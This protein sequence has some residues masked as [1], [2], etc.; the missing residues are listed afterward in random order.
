MNGSEGPVANRRLSYAW[1]T[2]LVAIAALASVVVLLI[3]AHRGESDKASREEQ[4]RIEAENKAKLTIRE[5]EKAHKAE[6]EQRQRAETARDQA[7]AKAEK[8]ARRQRNAKE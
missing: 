7:L 5:L 3:F 1:L 4:A 8:E 6:A 2:S